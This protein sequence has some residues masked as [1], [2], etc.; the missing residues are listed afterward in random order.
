MLP[1]LVSGGFRGKSGVDMDKL[2]LDDDCALVGKA[3]EMVYLKSR[4]MKLGKC[5]CN[6]EMPF[7][8][9][10]YT[11]PLWGEIAPQ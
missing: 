9:T 10:C 8:I 5:K 1:T 4:L 6:G 11:C 3:N 7:D 2:V